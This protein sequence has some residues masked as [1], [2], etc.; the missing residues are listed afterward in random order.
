[1]DY[2]RPRLGKGIK[3]SDNE[4]LATIKTNKLMLPLTK[5]MLFIAF[6]PFH[7][8]GQEMWTK[9]I[10]EKIVEH[11]PFKAC[12]ASTIVETTPGRLLVAFFGGTHEGNKDVNIWLA[13]FENGRWSAP[14]VIAEG[15]VNDTLRYPTWN[16]V[17]FRSAQGRVFLFYKVGPSPR[18]WWGM[19]KTSDD[20]GKTWSVSTRLPGKLLGP[21]K[22][23]PVQLP[24]GTILSP[25]ST[26]T[27][28]EWL[29]HIERSTDNGKTWQFIPVDN[30]SA[31]KA[32]QPSILVYPGNRMQLLCRSNQD[33]LVEAWSTDNGNT[34]TAL[35]KTEL[36]NPNS[37]TDAVTLRNGWQL[38]VY[39]PDIRGN[40][41]FN[42]RGKLHAAIAAQGKKWKDIMVLENGKEEEFSYPAVIQTQDGKVHITY[43]FD[44]KNIKHVVLDQVR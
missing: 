9:E 36:L 16:P 27:K 1:M 22:N 44:R 34:W 29:V 12:H 43:T 39:N 17:L 42:G 38:L 3:F 33:R 35:T 24:D 25:S 40:E 15:I 30:Q 41:W 21:V 28:D 7:G 6:I 10:E 2:S 4:I 23:K 20:D 18:K 13:G 32:I 11:P 31:F 5:V 19:V 26:E 14:K 8:L 37:G